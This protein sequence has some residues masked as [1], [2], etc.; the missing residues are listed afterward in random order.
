MQRESSK[1]NE[2]RGKPAGPNLSKF[3]KSL[4]SK[5][6]AQVIGLAQAVGTVELITPDEQQLLDA[7]MNFELAARAD[8]KREPNLWVLL[9]LGFL[10]GRGSVRIRGKPDFTKPDDN[11]AETIDQ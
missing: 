7:A 4:D 8:E 9:R 11:S 5:T 10:I 3:L 6:L 2:S 1:M